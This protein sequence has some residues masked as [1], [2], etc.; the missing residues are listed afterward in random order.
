MLG[1]GLVAVEDEVFVELEVEEAFLGVVFLLVDVLVL[2]VVLEVFLEEA[3][4]VFFQ[5]CK[6]S[7]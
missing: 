4:F 5:T 7:T 6:S 3:F 1:F 2:L